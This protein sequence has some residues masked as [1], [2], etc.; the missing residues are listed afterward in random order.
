ML[1]GPAAIAALGCGNDVVTSSS[2]GSGGNGGAADGGGDADACAPPPCAVGDCA[3]ESLATPTTQLGRAVHGPAAT[4]EYIYWAQSEPFSSWQL[5][6]VPR[7]GGEARLVSEGLGHVGAMSAVASDLYVSIRFDPET[8]AP[9][10]RIRRLSDEGGVFDMPGENN[11]LDLFATPAALYWI[12]QIV[13]GQAPFGAHRTSA[14]DLGSTTTY[15]DP[16]RWHGTRADGSHMFWGGVG[17]VRSARIDAPNAGFEVVM[18][19]SRTAAVE[20]V[21]EWLV[22]YDVEG[23]DDQDVWASR[24]DG[25]DRKLLLA[26]NLHPHFDSDGEHVYVATFDSDLHGAQ[27]IHRLSPEDGSDEVVLTANLHGDFDVD[28]GWLYAYS[29]DDGVIRIPLPSR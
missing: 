10:S 28:A 13:E 2:G 12:G 24:K 7:C 25:S 5:Y 14:P 18:P 16:D 11:A 27:E 9:P 4:V 6:Q 23:Q 3:A 8:W 26:R 15:I 21:G 29:L 22:G 1:A 19:L 20:L 17:G